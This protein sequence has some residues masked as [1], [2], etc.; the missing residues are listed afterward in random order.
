MSGDETHAGKHYNIEG[1]AIFT[2]VGGKVSGEG[3]VVGAKGVVGDAG[4][5]GP[6]D[7]K[8]H[9]D[10][11]DRRLDDHEHRLIRLETLWEVVFG[12]GRD[13]V[14]KWAIILI[15]TVAFFA[16]IIS[17]VFFAGG[18]NVP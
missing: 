12:P 16:V 10:S 1:D 17:V 18:I 13:S 9:D 3:N 14:P 6:Q 8:R 4:A 7:G 11:V 5:R 2:D 15:A